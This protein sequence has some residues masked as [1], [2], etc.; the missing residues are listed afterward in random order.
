MKIGLIGNMNN[1]NFALM[2]YFRDLGADAHLLLYSNDGRGTLS[3]FRPESDSWEIEKWRP[4]IHQTRIPNAPVAALDFPLSWLMAYY[5]FVRSRLGIQVAWEPPVSRKMIVDAYAGY[6]RYVAS[7][8]T[9]ATLN[10]V[11]RALDIFYPYSVGVEF[12]E[13]GEFKVRFNGKKTFSK[14]ILN[15][16]RERQMAG[17]RACRC[18][19]NYD[20]GITQ[21]VLMEIGVQA[22]RLAIPM[23]YNNER[24]P[25]VIPNLKIE[26]LLR[27]L[28]KSRF[29]ILHHSRLMWKNPGQYSVDSWRYENKNNNWLFHAFA[30]LLKKRPYLNPV[31]AVVEY[32]PDTQSTKELASQ[33]GIARQIHWLPKMDRRELM[34]LLSHV[35]IGIGEFYDVPKMIWGGTGWEVLASGKPLL[36]G[37]KFDPGEFELIYGYPPPPMLPVRSE[38]DILAH[39]VDMADNLDRREKI[40]KGAE[41]WFNRYNGIGLAKKWLDLLIT[42]PGEEKTHAAI[43]ITSA[44]A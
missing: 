11:S 36:Q 43:T 27:P 44:H 19:L 30:R 28:I 25:E 31:L 41:E 18:V 26:V 23:V 4:Y 40:G 33:L 3:H 6:D 8:I 13:T 22:V 20:M 10:R 15:H 42:S 37:F 32:G 29:S 17:V 24:M 12:L 9:P 34:W 1:N 35:A 16:I 14:K 2:R 21:D 39:L 7:G 38:D 5:S